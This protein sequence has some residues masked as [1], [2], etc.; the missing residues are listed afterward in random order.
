MRRVGV[1]L[2]VVVKYEACCSKVYVK[3][4]TNLLSFFYAKY[5]NYVVEKFWFTLNDLCAG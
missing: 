4:L 2:L 1:L 3:C 5:L